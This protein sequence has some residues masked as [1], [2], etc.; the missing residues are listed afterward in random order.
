[1]GLST[2]IHKLEIVAA[3][4]KAEQ[5]R[6]REN[7][8]FRELIFRERKDF[9]E[10]MLTPYRYVIGDDLNEEETT[11]DIIEIDLLFHEE[12]TD[13][14]G[15]DENRVYKATPEQLNEV[16]REVIFRFDRR[17]FGNY[18][19]AEKFNKEQEQWKQARADMEAGIDSAESEAAEYIRELFK[20]YPR[21]QGAERFYDI[22]D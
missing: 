4:I 8:E 20:R 7:A 13:R 15:I 9:I 21:K 1:M 3:P 19:T 16:S 6:K 11:K 17:I 12:A 22:W 5:A 2:R 18:Q 10:E 14:F